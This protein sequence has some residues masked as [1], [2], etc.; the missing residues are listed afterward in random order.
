MK[1]FI[2]TLWDELNRKGFIE[3]PISGRR[4]YKNKIDSVNPEKLFNYLI[5]LHETE[6]NCLVL[7]KIQEFLKKYETVLVLYTYDSFL[8]DVS[9]K[10]GRDFFLELK[11]IIEY[12]KFPTATKI[13][14]NY[15]KM[16]E[17]EIK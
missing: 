6:K 17:I 7:V 9:V 4:I 5:Q 16:K 12:G 14:N 15:G 3:A 1:K 8:F 11:Y 13:G 2:D 10:D